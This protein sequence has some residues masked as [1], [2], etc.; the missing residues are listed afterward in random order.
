MKMVTVVEMEAEIRI[1][2]EMCTSVFREDN[3]SGAERISSY[4]NH[5]AMRK[6]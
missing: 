5:G 3:L 4:G 2:E 1:F 6:S